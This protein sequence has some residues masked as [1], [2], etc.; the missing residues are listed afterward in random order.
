MR[1]VKTM[2]RVVALLSIPIL[3]YSADAKQPKQI[4]LTAI[5][6]YSAGPGIERAEIAAY[7]PATRRIFSINPTLSRVD[8]LDISD[9]SDPTLTFTIP[10]G[11]RPNS[12]AFHRGIVAVAVENAVKTDPGFVKFFDANG[13]LLS[14]VT[15]GALPDMLIF[16]PNG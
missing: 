5:G 2:I 14:T 9:P 7:D 13:T 1:R 6:R 15:V 4:G 10:L 3:S 11:G 12:V 8:V 16:T